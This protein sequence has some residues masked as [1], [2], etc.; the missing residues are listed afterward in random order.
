MKKELIHTRKIAVNCYETDE[1]RLIIEG[2]LLDER[3]FPFMIHAVNERR[4]AGP[5]HHV[6][7]TMEL[8]LPGME[9]LSVKTEMPVVPDAGCREIQ[10]R[11]Q[12]LTGRFIRPGFTNEVRDLL[13]K[14]EGC[15]H[16]TNLLLAMSSAAVQGLWTLVSRVRDGKAPPLP[17]MDGSIL[18]NSCYMWREGGP[19]EEK[20]RQRLMET[21]GKRR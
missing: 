19:F 5:M 3:L 20:I 4:E 8:S 11:M 12:K 9:I 18:R 16:L 17:K 6:A 21:K 2:I 1:D 14:A 7:L 10:Q 13:G 15:L